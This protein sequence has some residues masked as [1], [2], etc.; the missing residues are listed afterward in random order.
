[1]LEKRGCGIGLS[2]TALIA[3]TLS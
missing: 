3:N 1:M 2:I